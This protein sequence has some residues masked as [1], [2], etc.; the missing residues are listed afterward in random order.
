MS[1]TDKLLGWSWI[2]VSSTRDIC[3]MKSYLG[4]DF[5]RMCYSARWHHCIF[6]SVITDESTIDEMIDHYHRFEVMVDFP[7]TAKFL[8]P[9]ERDYIIWVKSTTLIV[10]RTCTCL[11]FSS[12]Y[13]NSSVGEEEHFEMRHLKMAFLDWQVSNNFHRLCIHIEG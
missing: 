11:F 12:E 1:G 10:S 4:S 9:E 13:D 7:S 8:T 3:G 6:W 2:F 5:G